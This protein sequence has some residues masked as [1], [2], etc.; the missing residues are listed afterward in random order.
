MLHKAKCGSCGTS[1][2]N[3]NDQCSSQQQQG[4]TARLLMHCRWKAWVQMPQTTGESSPG[5][6]PALVV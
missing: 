5:N 6:L 3:S 2:G 4:L 1:C